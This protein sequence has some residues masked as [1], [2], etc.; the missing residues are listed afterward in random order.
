LLRLL[1]ATA[2]CR[3]GVLAQGFCR[4]HEFG[5]AESMTSMEQGV[6]DYNDSSIPSCGVVSGSQRRRAL[7][8]PAGVSP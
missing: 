2:P 5:G 3:R 1:Q 6:W 4:Q 7:M 8:D